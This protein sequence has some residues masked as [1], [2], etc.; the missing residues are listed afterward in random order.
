[1]SAALGSSDPW[2]A[3]CQQVTAA[4]DTQCVWGEGAAATGASTGRSW[5][6]TA[7]GS[8]HELTTSLITIIF[9]GLIWL[10][11]VYNEKNTILD[12][13]GVLSAW[14]ISVSLSTLLAACQKHKGC[15]LVCHIS[16][17]DHQDIYLVRGWGKCCAKHLNEQCDHIGKKE[18]LWCLW[19]WVGL[20][21]SSSWSFSGESLLEP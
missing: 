9:T 11:C 13:S 20:F 21:Q 7:A 6:L 16:L 1:M 19:G 5:L 15:K 8:R 3:R 17:Q 18:V 4:E 2:F 12:S 14:V 10:V